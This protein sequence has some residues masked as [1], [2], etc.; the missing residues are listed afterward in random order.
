M[1][2]VFLGHMIDTWD[3]ECVLLGDFNEVH[4]VKE[5][6][7]TLFNAND[8][9]AFNNLITM[10]G[11]VNLPIE[12]YSFTW[13]HKSA[14]KMSKYDRFLISKGLLTLF[15][16]LSALY[17]DRH[18]SDHRPILLRELNMDYG[19]TPFRLFHSWFY[20][21]VLDKMVEDSWKSSVF[22]EQKET[23]GAQDLD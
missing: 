1:L 11:L 18:L 7:G 12:G 13:S 21:K 23:S 16:S 2:W 5:R 20:K 9:N 3:G 17:L 4:L 14:S 22:L 19:P 6:H 8:A 10:A 15:P